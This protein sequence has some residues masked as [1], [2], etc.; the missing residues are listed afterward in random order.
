VPSVQ[1]SRVASF[2][3]ANRRFT[4]SCCVGSELGVL[5]GNLRCLWKA[6]PASCHAS[7]LFSCLHVL[8]PQLDECLAAAFWVARHY[9]ARI[10]I[11]HSIFD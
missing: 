1:F 4:F 9:K 8:V 2:C 7:P 6:G 11:F 3:C 10:L 5:T